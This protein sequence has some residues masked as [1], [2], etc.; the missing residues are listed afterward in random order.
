MRK[1]AKG[2]IMDENL[3][4]VNAENEEAVNLEETEQVEAI[5]SEDTGEATTSTVEQNQFN[6]KL[7]ILSMQVS[8]ETQKQRQ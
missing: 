8:E 6:R 5:E 3:N 1:K 7:K 4:S 2:I